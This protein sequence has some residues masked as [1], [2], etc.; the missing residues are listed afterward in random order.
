MTN[1][2]QQ[3]GLTPQDF[4][5]ARAEITTEGVKGLFLINGGG[6]VALLAFLQAVGVGGGQ[7]QLAKFV[8][9][10]IG[11][12]CLG[13]LFAGLINFF[14]YHTSFNF[15]GGNTRRYKLF[16]FLSISFQYA[17]FNGTGGV[18]MNVT[19]V[20]IDLA[21]NTFSLHGVDSRGKTV[22]RKTLNRPKLLP[23]LGTLPRHV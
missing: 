5:S 14:R 10:G 16:R 17:S 1:G 13:L 6:S 2:T 20:G 9:I 22:F 19:T 11:I 23:F 8:V 4:H 3:Q 7:P 21:K 12:M 15:Q 18:A